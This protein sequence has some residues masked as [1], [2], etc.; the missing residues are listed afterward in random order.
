[1]IS[2]QG[3]LRPRPKSSRSGGTRSPKQ[4]LCMFPHSEINMLQ[5]PKNFTFCHENIK[6]SNDSRVQGDNS[7]L[8]SQIC[9]VWMHLEVSGKCSG[10]RLAKGRW[11]PWRHANEQRTAVQVTAVKYGEPDNRFG[12]EAKWV[13]LTHIFMSF[14]RQW[15]WKGCVGSVFS[16]GSFL[17]S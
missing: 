4:F 2:S 7:S 12:Q 11:S 8:W 1:M 6:F 3:P 15:V 16:L 13:I 10:W 9:R 17:V 14:Q 5:T